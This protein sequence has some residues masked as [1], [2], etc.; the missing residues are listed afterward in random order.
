MQELLTILKITFSCGILGFHDWT[1]AAAKGIRP[2]PEQLAN[3]WEGFK[4]YAKMY[5]Q[6]CGTESNLSK[7][8]RNAK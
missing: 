7:R 4:D 2:S 5:C 1:C 3:G 8:F 6:K